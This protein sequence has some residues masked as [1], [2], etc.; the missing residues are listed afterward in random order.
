MCGPATAALVAVGAKE[1]TNINSLDFRPAP[2]TSL[3]TQRPP[4]ASSRNF[5]WIGYYKNICDNASNLDRLALDE[6]ASAGT[7]PFLQGVLSAPHFWFDDVFVNQV[8]SFLA[9]FP[10]PTQKWEHDC[11][12]GIVKTLKGK[13]GLHMYHCAQQGRAYATHAAKYGSRRPSAAMDGWWS[14]P[15]STPRP[16]GT[17]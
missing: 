12:K 1:P 8:K 11:D 6:R 2:F 15:P 7:G 10:P 3:A 16:R 14:E 9:T 13:E 17:A 4:N 5:L